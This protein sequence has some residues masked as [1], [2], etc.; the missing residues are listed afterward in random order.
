M[1]RGTWILPQTDRETF[2]ATLLVTWRGGPVA[3]G[4]GAVKEF[5]LAKDWALGRQ[6]LQNIARSTPA[7]QSRHRQLVPPFCRC[8]RAAG[9]KERWFGGVAF[10]S[11]KKLRAVSQKTTNGLDLQAACIMCNYTAFNTLSLAVVNWLENWKE[12][13]EEHLQQEGVVRD[14]VFTLTGQGQRHGHWSKSKC[15]RYQWSTYGHAQVRRLFPNKFGQCRNF[16]LFTPSLTT[17]HPLCFCSEVK[18][19]VKVVA[20]AVSTKGI[21]AGNGEETELSTASRERHKLWSFTAVRWR[22][23]VDKRSCIR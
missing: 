12:A 21:A 13:S 18:T 20:S 10:P 1:D 6:E 9:P 3:V 8:M 23:W 17:P 11:G 22:P 16:P 15:M 2:L 5:L 14:Y 19:S 4:I 7:P